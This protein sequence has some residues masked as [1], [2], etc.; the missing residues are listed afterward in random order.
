MESV[1]FVSMHDAS[2][3]PMAAALFNLMADPSLAIARSAGFRPGATLDPLVVSSM[4]SAGLPLPDHAP[5]H[6]TYDLLKNATLVVHVGN[7]GTPRAA[8]NEL[9]WDV[10]LIRP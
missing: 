9:V 7:G 8:D 1:L 3:G 5:E 10:P 4:A 2:R 6:L